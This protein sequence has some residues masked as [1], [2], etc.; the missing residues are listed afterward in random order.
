LLK[1]KTACSD[2]WSDEFAELIARVSPGR[3]GSPH[4]LAPVLREEQMWDALIKLLQRF[5]GSFDLICKYADDLRSQYPEE[6]IRLMVPVIRQE[7]FHANK[8][9]S[10]R[11]I[12]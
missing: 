4:M 3:D 12:L 2:G 1:W 10:Y 6:V 5:S 11:K 8:R 9:S 7:A